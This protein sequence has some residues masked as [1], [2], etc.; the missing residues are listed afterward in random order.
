MM[1]VADVLRHDLEHTSD[2]LLQK[3]ILLKYSNDIAMALRQILDVIQN[4]LIES[5]EEIEG[6]NLFAIL[7][8]RC[9]N[10]KANQDALRL[11]LFQ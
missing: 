7:R 4:N 10:S 11:F 1:S 3:E 6:R 9:V 5:P 2:E 8:E